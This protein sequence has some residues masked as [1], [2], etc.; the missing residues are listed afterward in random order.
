MGSTPVAIAICLSN[1]C[2][3]GSAVVGCG[4]QSSPAGVPALYPE[5]AMARPTGSGDLDRETGWRRIHD[6]AVRSSGDSR[7]SEGA[8][9]LAGHVSHCTY[10]QFRSTMISW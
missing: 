10:I 5:I 8:Q 3:M 4:W 6:G 7:E 2:G 9:C 1:T